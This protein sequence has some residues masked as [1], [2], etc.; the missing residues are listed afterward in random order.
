MFSSMCLTC[1]PNGCSPYSTLNSNT[2]IFL[3]IQ[4]N[5]AAIRATTSIMTIPVRFSAVAASS[6]APP[7]LGPKPIAAWHAPTTSPSIP[8]LLVAC[9][10]P[11]LR[12][13]PFSRPITFWGSTRTLIGRLLAWLH[14]RRQLCLGW[15][16]VP[17]HTLLRS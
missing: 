5:A 7:V 6:A 2:G 14:V 8:T 10:P 1:A 17:T 12:I 13:S 15:R 3:A 11:L 9:R 16:Q 4:V